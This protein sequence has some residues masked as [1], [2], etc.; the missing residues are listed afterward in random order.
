MGTWPASGTHD[1]EPILPPS[2]KNCPVRGRFRFMWSAGRSCLVFDCN[3]EREF[4][5]SLEITIQIAFKNDGG[6]RGKFLRHRSQ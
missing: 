4:R 1:H 2:V 3:R 6:G 5:F